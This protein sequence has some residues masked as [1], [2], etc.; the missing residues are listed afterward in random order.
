MLL[1]QAASPLRFSVDR[2]SDNRI[3]GGSNDNL[4]DWDNRS[5]GKQ[6]F[7]L[8]YQFLEHPIS[9]TTRG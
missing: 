7:F 2:S 4:T 9:C 5:V 3:S 1:D 6:L 8:H